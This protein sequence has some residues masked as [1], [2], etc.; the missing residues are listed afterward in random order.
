[1]IINEIADIKAEIINNRVTQT[2]TLKKS[3]LSLPMH[4]LH[5]AQ[6]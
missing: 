5:Q 3:K 4:L 2:K 6:W 1:M